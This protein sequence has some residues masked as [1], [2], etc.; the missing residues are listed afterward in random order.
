[1]VIECLIADCYVLLDCTAA[2]EQWGRSIAE[3]G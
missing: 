2:F 3:D 1:M